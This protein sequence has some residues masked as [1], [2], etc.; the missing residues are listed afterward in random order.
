[1]SFTL[2]RCALRKLVGCGV[3]GVLGLALARTDGKPKL[4]RKIFPCVG[5]QDKCAASELPRQI[6]EGK[7]AEISRLAQ[8]WKGVASPPVAKDLA[9]RVESIEHSFMVLSSTNYAA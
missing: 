8:S 5:K 4:L 1:V 6:A 9:S 7:A 3:A 2:V